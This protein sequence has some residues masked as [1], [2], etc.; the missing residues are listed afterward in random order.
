MYTL[1]LAETFSGKYTLCT[2]SQQVLGKSLTPVKPRRTRRVVKSGAAI[3]YDEHFP[4]AAV[5][6][7]F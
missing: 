5:E 3:A 4:A 6:E 7:R 1:G 2:L